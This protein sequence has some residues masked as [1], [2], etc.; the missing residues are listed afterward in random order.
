MKTR[1]FVDRTPLYAR[2]GCGGNGCASFRREKRVP[3][4]GPDG[5]DGGKGGD[6]ILR[7]DL[8]V[9]SLVAIFFAPH[10][11][12]KDAGPGKGKRLHGRNG[13]DLVLKVPC[14]TEIWNTETGLLVADLAEH[15]AEITVA[16]GGKGGLGNW[17]WKSSTHKAPR[18]HT[19]GEPG[20]ELDIQLELKIAAD[21]GLV[22]FPNAGKSSLLSKLSEAHPKV[23]PYP[24]TTMNP[25]V[26]TVIFEDY[27]RLK[28]ADI[29]GL[30]DGAHRGVGLGH[31][32][33]R[34]VERSRFLVY[35][36]DMAGVDGRTPWDDYECLRKELSL[37]NKE[38][39]Q[40]PSLVVA[41]KMDLQE[42][43]S[44][45]QTFR[46]E[47]GL[48]PLEVSALSGEGID[49]LRSA[50]HGLVTRGEQS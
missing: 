33:L 22:G 49:A 16:A 30:I 6:V 42:A 32:F 27:T 21:A 29:P 25:I 3:M 18:E 36:V 37:H 50:L 12:A 4:G 41:N 10:R 26:G 28:I 5:G 8:E 44:L 31:D 7:A 24:F 38:L 34:H 11:R 39:A 20:E 23:A 2:A 40:R 15:G 14:G 9:D 48:E 46:D 35:V 17:H 45:V 1:K 43:A 13:A 19:P 47:T